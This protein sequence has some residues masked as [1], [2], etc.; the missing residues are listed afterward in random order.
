MCDICS[1]STVA[2]VMGR[3][4]PFGALGSAFGAGGALFGGRRGRRG[5]SAG[6]APGGRRGPV[7]SGAATGR[8]GS[9]G[10]C[11]VLTENSDVTSMPPASSH[12]RGPRSSPG[13]A[14]GSTDRPLACAAS[15]AILFLSISSVRR[16]M[17]F[18][19]SSTSSRSG[20][21]LTRT[22]THPFSPTPPLSTAAQTTKN[23]RGLKIARSSTITITVLKRSAIKSSE[24]RTRTTNVRMAQIAPM[25]RT[26]PVRSSRFQY[27]AARNLASSLR[28]FVMI[29]RLKIPKN[30]EVKIIA[31]DSAP[32]PITTSRSCHRIKLS[33]SQG[34]SK[35]STRA[36]SKLQF[37]QVSLP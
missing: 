3:A 27:M 23:S 7:A 4:L 15:R 32:T 12:S 9:V 16:T 2:S 31:A 13:S 17:C 18:V 10:I 34:P 6:L 21:R 14:S 28:W 37:A 25:P 11:G 20:N 26:H 30:Q 35:G 33:S 22:S 5:G 29:L 36:R 19:D 1:F 8:G 24:N